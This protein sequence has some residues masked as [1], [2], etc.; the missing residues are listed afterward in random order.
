MN[1]VTDFLSNKLVIGTTLT[2]IGLHQ[3]SN[4]I[5]ARDLK[6]LDDQLSFGTDKKTIKRMLDGIAKARKGEVIAYA[7]EFYRDR[8][9]VVIG[10]IRGDRKTEHKGHNVN[11]QDSRLKFHDE[12]PVASPQDLAALDVEVDGYW[13]KWNQSLH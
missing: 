3:F 6:A 12:N 2:L 8:G 4:V 5:N 13:K 7:P 9:Y 11:I 1:A 10:K